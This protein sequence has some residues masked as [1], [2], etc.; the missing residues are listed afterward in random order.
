MFRR[1]SGK[2]QEGVRRVPPS[3][4]R[5]SQATAVRLTDKGS[6]SPRSKGSEREDHTIPIRPSLPAGLPLVPHKQAA[7][8]LVI[9]Q[10]TCRDQERSSKEIVIAISET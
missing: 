7:L 10:S 6:V 5:H 3:G 2:D 9:G 8:S 4:A 1:G